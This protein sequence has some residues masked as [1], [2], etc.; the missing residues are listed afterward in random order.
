MEKLISAPVMLRSEFER[1]IKREIENAK[2]GKKAEIFAKMNSLVDQGMIKLF[3]EASSVGVKIRLIVRGICCLKT[4]I[5]GVSDNIE[6][7]SIVGRFLEH[8]RVYEFENDG[9]REVYLSSADMMP[10]NLNRRV[11]LLF[12]V[13]N[14][15]IADNIMNI[16]E[17][18]WS[19]NCQTSILNGYKYTKRETGEIAVNAQQELIVR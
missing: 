4:G 18:Y 14:K 7:H 17:L 13:E 15:E 12:P 9:N 1:L 19:D 6:V 10:R 5:K 8:S 3:Y 11:E 2:K 16:M